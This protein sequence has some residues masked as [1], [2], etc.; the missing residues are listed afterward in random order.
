ME[1]QQPFSYGRPSQRMVNAVNVLQEEKAT[2]SNDAKISIHIWDNRFWAGRAWAKQRL[3]IFKSTMDT[4][5]LRAKYG[6]EEVT[7]LVLLCHWAHC[8]WVRNIFWDLRSHARRAFGDTWAT[9]QMNTVFHVTA[10]DALLQAAQSTFWE[11]YDG[12]TLLFWCWPKDHQ[13]AALLGYPSWIVGALLN[14]RAPQRLEKSEETQT[15]VQAKLHTVR[16]RR[17]VCSGT[18]K[19]LTSYFSVPKGDKDI[20]LVYD[21]SKSGLN[22][23]LWSLSFHLPTVD[24]LVRMMSSETWMGDLNLGEMFHNFPLDVGLQPHCGI[25]MSP[26]FA[27]VS[28]WERWVRLM[29]G[30]C[31]SPYYSI[32]DLQIALESVLSDRTNPTNVFHWSIVVLNLPSDAKYNPAQPGSST[33]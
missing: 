19:S 4:L 14:Y 26:Y 18:V 21:A 27:E 30:L 24:D 8:R 16:Q 1:S 13:E 11:W 3:G 25:D 28:S 29:M 7:P 9:S 33:Q 32:K 5:T 2:R 12:S 17:Y 15:M 10:T 22:S 23:H 20:R 6:C 31:P